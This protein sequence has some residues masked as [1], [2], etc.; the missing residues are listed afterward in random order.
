MKKSRAPKVES[1]SQLIDA[2]I[3][4]LDDWRG[5]KLSHPHFYYSAK[6]KLCSDKLT[7]LLEAVTKMGTGSSAGPLLLGRF[8]SKI[9]YDSRCRCACVNGNRVYESA[10]QF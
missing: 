6:G 8:T 10:S 4:E 7:G 3:R 5:K 9:H 1:T 2:I